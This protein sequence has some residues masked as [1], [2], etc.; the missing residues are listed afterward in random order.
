MLTKIVVIVGPTA[1][2]KSEL[3]ISIAKKFNGEIISADSR[4]VYRGM[5]IGTAKPK[6]IKKGRN[7]FFAGVRH[8]L[9]DVRSV[10]QTFTVKE[11]KDLAEKAAKGIIKRGKVPIVAGGTGLYIKALVDNLN[12]AKTRPDEKLRKKLGREL[13]KKGLGALYQRLVR[14]D[15]E[16]AYIVDP[17]NPRRVIR[18]LEIALTRKKPLKNARARNKP[19]FTALQIGIDR[20]PSALKRKIEKRAAV[21]IKSGL[22]GEVKKLIEKYPTAPEPLSAIGYREVIEYLEGKITRDE[23]IERMRSNTWRYAKKQTV[24]FRKDRRIHWVK[25]KKEAEFLVKE[26]MRLRGAEGTISASKSL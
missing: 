11:F 7:F 18:A 12:F 25:T 19:L 15:P 9:V 21:M 23:A 3:A 5:D 10:D 14:A 4:Q 17:Q 24:W 1:S 8:H 16:A 22:V 20:R 13:D 26:F 2:G 6:L